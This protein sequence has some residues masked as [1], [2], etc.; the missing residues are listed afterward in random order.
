MLTVTFSGPPGCGKTLSMKLAALGLKDAGFRALTHE[1]ADGPNPATTT[2]RQARIQVLL[3]ANCH[4]SA[5]NLV[6]EFEG[7]GVRTKVQEVVYKAMNEAKARIG[8]SKASVT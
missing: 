3:V 6:V 4:G 8:R 7:T 1:N 2:L 5:P